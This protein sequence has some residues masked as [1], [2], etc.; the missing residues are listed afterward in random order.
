MAPSQ[1]VTPTGYALL[2]LLSFGRHLTGYELKQ[3]AE[4]SLRFFYAAPAMSQVYSE[5]HKLQQA[6]LVMAHDTVDGAR[7]IRVH[8]ISRRG[9]TALRRWLAE[10]PVDPPSLKHHLALRIFL[11]HLI[12]PRATAATGGWS[13][14][15]GASRWSPI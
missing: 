12:E 8:S 5:L 11:G 9:M 2:G 6:G 4:S 14:L 1:Q 10:S 7:T 13:A 3:F 15:P